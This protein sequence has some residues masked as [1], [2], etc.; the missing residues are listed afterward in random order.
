MEFWQNA[1]TKKNG[2]VEKAAAGWQARRQNRLSRRCRGVCP[3]MGI[4]L[5]AA[6][7]KTCVIRTKFF[8]ISSGLSG[9]GV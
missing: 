6:R 8:R 5:I 9:L 2:I 7:K 1:N 3:G 4:V